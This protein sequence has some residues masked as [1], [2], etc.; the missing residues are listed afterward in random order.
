MQV[1][2]KGL[3]SKHR[4]MNCKGC[5]ER[6]WSGDQSTAA[7]RGTSALKSPR[8]PTQGHNFAQLNSSQKKVFRTICTDKMPIP[9]L[10]VDGAVVSTTISL[11]GELGGRHGVAVL[12]LSRPFISHLFWIMGTWYQNG[13]IVRNT[14]TDYV[15]S[16]SPTQF[17]YSCTILVFECRE[18][19]FPSKGSTLTAWWIG[20]INWHQR[21]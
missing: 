4:I 14:S 19:P 18:T 3:T 1:R 8:S 9:S 21:S 11:H 13:N 7:N 12:G 15:Y 20:H 16:S 17:D 10:A 6:W 2:N 5:K